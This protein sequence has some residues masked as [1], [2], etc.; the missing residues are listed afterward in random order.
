MGSDNSEQQEQQ[1]VEWLRATFRR[2]ERPLVRF[3]VHITGDLERARDVVQ[4]T[5]FKLLQVDPERLQERV[6]G[7]LF[8]TCRNRA[9]DVMKKERR[10]SYPGDQQLAA[11]QH[12]ASSPAAMAEARQQVSEV[13]QVLQQLP[14]KQQEVVRLKLQAGLSYSEIS[15]VTGHSVNHVGVLLHHALKTI[16]QHFAA[17]APD[18]SAPER[19]VSR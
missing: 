14:D 17:R 13:L 8:R 16:R 10:M 5:F 4:D 6:A 11:R 18:R 2:Y 19:R 15:D 7:W 9:L 12:G 1:R 3:A